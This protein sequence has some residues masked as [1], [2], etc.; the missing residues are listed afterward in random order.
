[1]RVEISTRWN[2]N[3]THMDIIRKWYGDSVVV[4][5]GKSLSWEEACEF[6]QNKHRELLQIKPLERVSSVRAVYSLRDLVRALRGWRPRCPVCHR[7][8][9]PYVWSHGSGDIW[10]QRRGFSGMR[11]LDKDVIDAGDNNKKRVNRWV[12]YSPDCREK[13]GPNKEEGGH[14]DCWT[15]Y[16]KHEDRRYWRELIEAS[17]IREENRKWIK[18]SKDTLKEIRTYLRNQGKLELLGSRKMA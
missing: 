8:L 6:I 5:F 10:S 4:M 18:Q 13:L 12:H 3:S 11:G 17:R 1:M 14:D 16:I 15:A 7:P 9:Q 2:A